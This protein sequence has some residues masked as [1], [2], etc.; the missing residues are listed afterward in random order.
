MIFVSVGSQ[1]PFNRLT[2]AVETWAEAHDCTEDIFYQ[3]GDGTPPTRGVWAR[4]L[5]PVEFE[6]YCCNAELVVSH[7][8]T[9]ILMVTSTLKRKLLIF[10]RRFSEPG[11]I[12]NDHQMDSAYRWFE[13]KVATVAFTVEEL[14]ACLNDPKH[15]L[16]PQTKSLEA[17]DLIDAVCS[18]VQIASNKLKR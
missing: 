5:T 3:I 10:P 7:A 6:K 18:F 8:G 17:G 14:H 15:I 2:Q 16:V 9:G 4:Q 1:L 11:E 13:N 12:R